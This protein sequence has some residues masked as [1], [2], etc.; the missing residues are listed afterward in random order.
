MKRYKVTGARG[1]AGHEPGEF[2][3]AD[4]SPGQESRAIARGAIEAVGEAR[5]PKQ[6]DETGQDEDA[7]GD[8][9]AK[10]EAGE[11]PSTKVG[12]LFGQQ[13]PGKE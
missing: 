12:G 3:R 6:S 8:A 5:L 1:F 4:L 11:T 13:R 2:F 7:T 9:G 10:S